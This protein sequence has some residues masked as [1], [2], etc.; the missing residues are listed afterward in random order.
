MTRP[1]TA[2]SCFRLTLSARVTC[3]TA[4]RSWSSWPEDSCSLVALHS[5]GSRTSGPLALIGKQTIH[6][7]VSFTPWCVINNTQ[8]SLQSFFFF[9]VTFGVPSVLPASWQL[10]QIAGQDLTDV[11]R[12]GCRRDGRVRSITSQRQS[13]LTA[14][15]AGVEQGFLQPLQSRELYV[16]MQR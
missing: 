9:F 15:A 8:Q 1:C 11:G 6:K 12:D 13:R 16:N 2:A 14:G 4:G 10:C 7:E 3:L 5:S